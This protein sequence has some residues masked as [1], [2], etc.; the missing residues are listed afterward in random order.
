[1]NREGEPMWVTP[2]QSDSQPEG[3]RERVKVAEQKTYHRLISYTA[4]LQETGDTRNTDCNFNY[5][6]LQTLSP[7]CPVTSK[8]PVRA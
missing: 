6:E 7:L 5:Q 3:D 8:K 2:H 1:M 4:F